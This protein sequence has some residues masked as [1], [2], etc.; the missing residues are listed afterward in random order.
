MALAWPAGVIGAYAYLGPK[1]GRDVFDLK[2]E[3]ADI[4]FGIVTVLTGVLGTVCQ[5]LYSLPSKGYIHAAKAALCCKSMHPASTVF[6]SLQLGNVC[7]LVL[8]MPSP[9]DAYACCAYVPH[10]V[11][12][13]QSRLSPIKGYTLSLQ[14]V[15]GGV[16]LDRVGSSISNACRLCAYAVTLGGIFCALSF[17][18]ST[19][20]LQFAPLF[21]AGELGLFAIQVLA[22]ILTFPAVSQ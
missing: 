7:G 18:V 9:M 3:T 8:C 21:A 12:T 13:K 5:I 14:Q 19:S 2:P 1:A 4:A 22:W 11:E 6:L 15:I 16:V 20:L 10:K 17:A